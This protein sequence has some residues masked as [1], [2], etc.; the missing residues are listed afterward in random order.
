MRVSQLIVTAA[1]GALAAALAIGAVP[2]SARPEDG[3]GEHDRGARVE[4]SQGSGG[5][6]QARQQQAPQAQQ[7]AAPQAQ[8]APRQQWEG[9]QAT[10]QAQ[11][12][13]GRQ[14]RDD[15]QRQQWQAQRQAQQQ[16]QIQQQQIQAQ[17]QLVQRQQAQQRQQNDRQQ[18][19]GRQQGD[20]QQ[21]QGRRDT[22]QAQLPQGVQ[23]WEAQQLRQQQQEARNWN[24]RRN[25]TYTD[26]NRSGTYV[27]RNRTQ[28]RYRSGTRYQD[29]QY[30]YR[31]N[32]RWDRNWRT[33]NRY[34]W[35]RYRQTNRF[36]F[37]LGTYYSPYNNYSYR[38]LGIGSVLAQ[39][40]YGQNYWID[41]P[42]QYR[43]PDVYGPYRWVRYY[44]DALLVDIYSGEVVDVIYDFFW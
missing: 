10:Q 29:N 20:R 11:Q 36:V 39:L 13:Q 5:G 15:S 1:T 18:W 23:P 26:R 2:A 32:Q 24:D 3:D 27:D 41:D 33:N 28:D 37:N 19:Q 38:R 14:Q 34:D 21:W 31:N 40:F 8:A 7:Q 12:W 25:G 35:Q 17:Q 16:A 4:R 43:L 6:W 9:R 30:A 42:W 44:D 22:Q